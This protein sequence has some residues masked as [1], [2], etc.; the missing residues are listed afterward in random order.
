MKLVYFRVV[1]R[2]YSSKDYCLLKITQKTAI[3]VCYISINHAKPHVLFIMFCL[4]D[5]TMQICASCF[6]AVTIWFFEYNYIILTTGCSTW[7]LMAKN[8]EDLRI[9]IVAHHKDGQSHKKFGNS[10]EW[11]Y[12]TVV[13]DIQSF[14]KMGFTRNRPRKDRSKKLSPCAVRCRSWLQKTK[15]R[16]LPALLLRMQKWKV[17]LSGLRP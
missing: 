13:R 11:S 1:S 15:A 4:L 16:V 3:I 10:L 7:H 5:R 2:R 12:S 14:S 8:S 17:S 6:R 9:R